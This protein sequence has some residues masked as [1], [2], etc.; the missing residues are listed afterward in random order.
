MIRI[1]LYQGRSLSSRLI[2][3]QTRSRYSHAALLLNDERVVEA[4]G[5]PF[6]RGAVRRVDGLGAQHTPGT[7]VDLFAVDAPVDMEPA[8][9]WL[10]GVIGLPYDYRSVLRFLTR[11][12]AA[13]NRRYFCSELVFAFYQAGN[14]DLL[15]GAQAHDMSPR[16]LSLSPYLRHL[17]RRTTE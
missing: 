11:V 4:T 8:E 3:L 6:P 10:F 2:R 1:A 13:E 12:P 16:D 14:L 5:K 15:R 9:R 7:I 17:E